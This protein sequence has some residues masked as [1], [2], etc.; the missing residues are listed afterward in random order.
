MKAVLR[1][2]FPALTVMAPAVP[3]NAGPFEDS[4]A[5]Y[6][7][8]DYV[9]DLF[10]VVGGK[11]IPSNIAYEHS[12]SAASRCEQ[13]IIPKVLTLDPYDRHLS[14]FWLG[15]IGAVVRGP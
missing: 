15:A 7:R 2:V 11:G 14:R 6:D 13:P 4:L 10:P 3:A 9:L 5:A 1:N 8:G 12:V